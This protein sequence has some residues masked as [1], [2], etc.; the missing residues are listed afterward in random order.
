MVGNSRWDAHAILLQ[1]RGAVGMI[2]DKSNRPMLP[3]EGW[4]KCNRLGIEIYR[5]S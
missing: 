5:Y 1:N 2:T 4:P 3:E